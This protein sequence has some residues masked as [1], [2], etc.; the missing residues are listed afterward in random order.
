MSPISASVEFLIQNGDNISEAFGNFRKWKFVGGTSLGYD[1]IL[2]LVPGLV[3][4]FC[5]LLDE[6]SF[7]LHVFLPSYRSASPEPWTVGGDLK[8]RAGGLFSSK[9]SHQVASHSDKMELM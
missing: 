8:L 4:L 6:N 2:C 5:L 1:C 7:F 3:I 9:L